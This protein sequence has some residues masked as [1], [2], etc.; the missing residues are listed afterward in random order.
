MESA[1]PKCGTRTWKLGWLKEGKIVTSWLLLIRHVF[2]AHGSWNVRVS[3]VLYCQSLH[4]CNELWKIKTYV[5]KLFSKTFF[6][7]FYLPST[8]WM[9]IFSVDSPYQY[10]G[11]DTLKPESF[12]I[13]WVMFWHRWSASNFVT[14]LEKSLL[15]ASCWQNINLKQIICAKT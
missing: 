14:L 11:R 5:C 4:F 6:W 12:V 3:D 9:M 2:V 13:V 1:H 10:R 8:I 7:C 15:Q